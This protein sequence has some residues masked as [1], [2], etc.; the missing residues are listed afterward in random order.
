MAV[1]WPMPH[2]Q[3]QG[4][5]KRCCSTSAP[6]VRSACR[7]AERMPSQPSTRSAWRSA[8]DWSVGEGGGG[9]EGYLKN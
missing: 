9:L 2:H 7:T 6:A 5:A 1:P 3:G 8:T 4:T